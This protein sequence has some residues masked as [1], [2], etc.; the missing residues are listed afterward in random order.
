MLARSP[1]GPRPVV[2]DASGNAR[3]LRYAPDSIRFSDATPSSFAELKVGDQ[4]RALGERSAD[5]SRFTPEEIISGPFRRVGG[6]VTAVNTTAGEIRIKDEQTGKP[7]VVVVG[8]RSTLRRIPPEVTASLSRAT[9]VNHSPDN[10]QPARGDAR[11]N[12]SAGGEE[13]SARAVGRG[14]NFQE[15]FERLPAITLADLK[16]GDTILVTGTPGPDPARVTA[17]TLMTGDAA[18]LGRMLRPQG[19][20]LRGE[21]NMSPGLPSTVVGGG[22][23]QP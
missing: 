13:S 2:I 15:M 23:R 6:R 18:F 21:Q 9:V 22:D 7:L 5:G 8:K 16:Q 11:V 19:Q 1:D 14:R 12:N 17:V 20:P 10:T 3:F 4:L